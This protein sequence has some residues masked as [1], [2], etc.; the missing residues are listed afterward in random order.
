[1]LKI[2]TEKVIERGEKW[3]RIISMEG[4]MAQGDMPLK[5][6]NGYPRITLETL[7]IDGLHS[8]SL[9]QG[10]VFSEHVWQ[11]VVLPGIREAGERLHALRQEEKALKQELQGTETYII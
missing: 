1:M 5:Y 7:R 10:R 2:E 3:R 11:N 6:V 9:E 4:F 8:F